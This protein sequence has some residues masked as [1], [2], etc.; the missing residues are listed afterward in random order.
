AC[1]D[2]RSTHKLL[3][4]ANIASAARSLAYHEYN[5]QQA[6]PG[7]IKLISEG[8]RVVLVSDAGLPGLSDPGYRVLRLCRENN[9]DVEVIPGA[10]A[11]PMALL[12]SGLPTSS[13]TFKGFVPKKPGARARF[14]SEEANSAHVLV[15]YE[16][17][18]RLAE[19]LGV[20]LEALGDREA[21]VALE[22]TKMHERCMR[23][24]LTGLIGQLGSEPPK[25]EAV[26]VI[27]P[28]PRKQR[29]EVADED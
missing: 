11:A 12:M 8:K 27:A 20:A 4:L 19:T 22:M 6:A 26:L 21:A 7:L 25:G 14:F 29:Q 15:A 2:T 28:L 13:Y 24:T 23:G 18:L 5:E 1:E 10:H 17:P 3:G 16:S 9:I